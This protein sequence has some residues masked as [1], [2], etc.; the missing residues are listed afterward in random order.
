MNRV[1]LCLA[2]VALL[3]GC[4]SIGQ[5]RS[6]SP[7]RTANVDAHYQSLADCVAAKAKQQRLGDDLSYEVTDSVAARIASVVAMARY[8]GGLFYTVP[9]PLFELTFREPDEGRVK[10]EARRGPLGAMYEPALWAIVGDCAGGAVA[11]SPP[12]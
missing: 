11:V 10:I 4:L 1:S 8:P 7:T 3:T 9:T 12:L 2:A 5:I 6:S